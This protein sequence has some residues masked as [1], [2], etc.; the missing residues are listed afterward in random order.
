MDI[1]T[2]DTAILI[3]ARSAHCEASVKTSVGNKRADFKLHQLLL[4]KTSQTVIK[5]GLDFFAVD[6]S[7]QHGASFGQKLAS[8]FEQIFHL[9]YAKV[10]AIG[11]DCPELQ[12]ADLLL[13]ASYLRSGQAVLGPDKR[14]GVYLIGMSSDQF[15]AEQFSKLDWQSDQTLYSLINYFTKSSLLPLKSDINTYNDLRKAIW[16]LKKGLRQ[17]IV[18]IVGLLKPV[19]VILTR[20]RLTQVDETSA[21]LRAPP[22]AL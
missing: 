13:A 1:P 11:S 5:S 14:Q 21:L 10:I 7:T 22:A 8:A 19:N 3:F 16:L 12:T 4:N 2:K 20:H 15:D 9:G 6:E 17:A 18:Q